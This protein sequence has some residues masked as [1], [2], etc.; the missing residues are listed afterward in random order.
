MQY[1]NVNDEF[2]ENE[3]F[4]QKRNAKQSK[5]KWREIESFKERQK[6]KREL[7]YFEDYS[8]E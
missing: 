4:Q 7:A 6:M 1:R 2:D 8:F 3:A 5:K